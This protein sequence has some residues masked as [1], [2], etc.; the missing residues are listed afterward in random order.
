MC[1][2]VFK[3][4]KELFVTIYSES[5]SYSRHSVGIIS[6][7]IIILA[8]WYYCFHFIDEEMSM[9]RGRVHGIAR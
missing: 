2:C 1:V 8:D 3:R 6:Y 9:R 4:E 5:M 7:L